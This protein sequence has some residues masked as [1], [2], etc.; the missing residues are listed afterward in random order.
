MILSYL[1]SF[2]SVSSLFLYFLFR[3][4]IHHSMGSILF[5]FSTVF[6]IS[7][8]LLYRIYLNQKSK[9]NN[10]FK[11][12]SK[13][14]YTISS[15]GLVSFFLYFLYNYLDF[16]IDGKAE[17]VSNIPKIREMLLVFVVLTSFAFLVFIAIL[18]LKKSSVQIIS[19]NDDNKFNLLDNTFFAF[20]AVLPIIIG[21]NYLAVYRN[22]NFDLSKDKKFSL[23]SVSKS[24]I[25]NISKD[26]QITGFFPR[27]LES[28]NA[29]TSLSALRP[30]IELLFDD[31]KSTNPNFQTNFIN[32]DIETESLGEF[33]QVSNGVIS[34]RIRKSNVVAG[35]HPYLEQRVLAS[36]KEDLVE[37]EKQIVQAII[38]VT[39][40]EKKVYFTITN[41]ERAGAGFEKLVNEKVS[42]L[43]S[44]LVFL[45]YNSNSLGYTEKW[46]S[47]IPEDADIVAI[48]GPTIKFD[49]ASKTAILDFVHKRR[50]K[51]IITIEPKGDEDFNWLLSSMGYKFMN[52]GLVH[53]EG[54]PGLFLTD[55][56]MKHP[57]SD[58]LAKKNMSLLFAHS[59]YFLK[60]ESNGQNI[61]KVLL[62][63]GDNIFV[64]YNGNAKLDKD[65]KRSSV[66]LALVYETNVQ[67][68]TAKDKGRVIV[69]SGTSWLTDQYFLYNINPSFAINTFTWIYQD[70]SLERIPS[71]K[72]NAEIITL[73]P[74]QKLIIWAVGMFGYP[75]FV[76]LLLTAYV[77]MKRKK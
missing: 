31:L 77:F 16:P 29:S 22:V 66:P 36:S 65:E 11:P 5:Q 73:N 74:N 52:H 76:T 35:Q 34:I 6:L 37:L 63:S 32:A 48:I 25:K 61:G 57:I 62:E 30:Y 59:G 71:R 20:L 23:S 27:P 42:R 40:P 58:L 49:E 28:S 17:Q 33:G 46:P 15:L 68:S 51:L 19:Q 72:E 64:D 60:D 53:V 41:G 69:Y 38:N 26:V 18:E 9:T 47:H 45:N 21:V 8:D 55:K 43:M 75:A 2:I 10:R 7:I 1:I 12:E 44:S 54:K 67:A 39:T 50:G 3:D 4:M 24:L 13:L 14:R 70:L 56:F